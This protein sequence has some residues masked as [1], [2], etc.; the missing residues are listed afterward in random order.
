MQTADSKPKG[1]GKSSFD[2]IESQKVFKELGLQETSIFLDMACGRGDYSLAAAER[3][4]ALG[5]VYAV[6]LWQE[7]I[8]TLRKEMQAR[9]I[10]NIR[11]IVA[12]VGSLIEIG[13][14]SID[15]C[16]M[17]TV[18]HDLVPTQDAEGA[19]EEAARVLKQNGALV[20]IEFKK[21]PGPPG[22]PVDVRL[23]AAEVEKL[24]IP[25]GF[26]KDRLVEVGPYNYLVR[27]RVDRRE[28]E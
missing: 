4:G 25:H 26:K 6:D 8:D 21:I 10:P 12:D 20:I 11:A 3:V 23:T 2:L 13:D 22:P 24:V 1:A 28:R 7:G 17:A 19:L 14:A 9:G 15:V 5:K 27:F 18:L 16:L